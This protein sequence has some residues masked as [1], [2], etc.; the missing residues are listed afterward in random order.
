[1]P[2]RKT[3]AQYPEDP[4]Q[5][6]WG[7]RLKAVKDRLES[8]NFQ[9]LTAESSGQAKDMALEALRQRAPCLVSWGGSKTFVQTGLYEAVLADPAFRVLDTYAKN[10]TR[11]E[12]IERRRQALL[13]DVFVTGTNA[14]TE[15]GHL[16]NL[17]MIGNRVAAL[18]FGPK[19]VLI[20]VGRNK[21]VPDLSS[22][23][24]RIKRYSAPVNAVRLGKKTPCAKTGVCQNCRSP[25]RICNTWTVSEKS[26][27]AGRVCVVL[28][29]EDLGF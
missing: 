6:H 17:D 18:T 22:A 24:D 23:M 9:V 8:N 4:V 20:L 29:N 12:S 1:M 25:E 28:I 21:I 2:A 13:A 3:K 26:F 15:Q 14:L 7:H 16:V 10:M 11:E 27:P 5:T 19:Y